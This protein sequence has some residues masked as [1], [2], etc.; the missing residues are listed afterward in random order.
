MAS[1]RSVRREDSALGREASEEQLLVAS[2]SPSR[3]LNLSDPEDKGHDPTTVPRRCTDVFWIFPY[4]LLLAG[5]VWISIESN[6]V[7][8]LGV[9]TTLP[10]LEGK[11]CG[12]GLN[13]NKPYLYFCM[14]KESQWIMD[15]HSKSLDVTSP[16]CVQFCPQSWNTSSYCYQGINGTEVNESSKSPE[17]WAW[18]QNY[19]SRPFIGMLCRP[20]KAYT[21]RLFN[22]FEDFMEQAPPSAQIADVIRNFEI[23]LIVFGVACTSSYAYIGALGFC[24]KCLVWGAMSLIFVGNA[25]A[26]AVFWWMW[27]HT[28]G[29]GEDVEEA[30]LKCFGYGVLTGFIALCC[31]HQMR[32]LQEELSVAGDTIQV[33]CKCILRHPSLFALPFVTL[34]NRILCFAWVGWV[35]MNFYTAQLNDQFSE[36]EILYGQHTEWQ[37]HL[38]ISP[39]HWACIVIILFVGYW[40]QGVIT[41]C[42]VF[43][44]TFITQA[45]SFAFQAGLDDD[46]DPAKEPCCSIARAMWAMIRYHSGT[47]VF[48]GLLM[49]A[50]QPINVVLGLFARLG[51]HQHNPVALILSGCCDSCI[52]LYQ[53]NLAHIQREALIDVSLQ[54]MPFLQ[55]GHHLLK[56]RN[57]DGLTAVQVLDNATW[58]F[59]IAGL[60]SNSVIG[61]ITVVWLF[62]TQPAYRLPESPQFVEHPATTCF[63][64]A[65]VGLM[66]AFPFMSLFDVVS[67]AVMHSEVTL[68]QRSASSK[69]TLSP[70]VS[71]FLYDVA[72]CNCGPRGA[73]A[74]KAPAEQRTLSSRY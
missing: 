68:R 65:F 17:E 39:Y 66:T 60:G 12:F 47:M 59:Q 46:V 14:Q 44:T 67:D 23:L 37:I 33:A 28:S 26:S 3:V 16:I 71:G 9:L 52:L 43:I 30:R 20:H 24:A 57:Q 32:K 40:V 15:E 45:W 29:N 54:S 13:R 50:M 55:A 48:G 61:Y 5:S 42:A 25:G 53:N 21:S 10:D 69:S 62:R 35:V 38:E 34:M 31:L 36:V 41:A 74:G 8:K 63:V 18:I 58:L 22:Q 72:S 6:K 4:L 49:T 27:Y 51:Q 19:P 2:Q 56:V 64:G 1:L 7:G 70:T 11:L 73:W